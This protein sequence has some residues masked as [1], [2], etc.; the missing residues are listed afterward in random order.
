[1]GIADKVINFI[2]INGITRQVTGNDVEV[3][4]NAIYV[5]NKEITKVTAKHVEIEWK[6]ELAN[7]TVKRGSVKC[8]DTQSVYAEENVVCGNV[9]GSVDAGGNVNC[10]DVGGSIE[11]HDGN[12][13]C[14]SVGEGVTAEGD[15]QAGSV[16]A[17]VGSDGNVNCGSVGSYIESG[18]N[19]SCGNVGGN[20]EAEDGNVNCG[21]VNGDIIAYTV[22]I[23]K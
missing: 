13:V 9:E 6:G 20:V 12:I 16:G 4:N 19:V 3:K 10:G 23:E 17:Y 5:N 21:T 14:K 18:G 1:M 8:G 22:R 11:T 7:L 15:V 2:K